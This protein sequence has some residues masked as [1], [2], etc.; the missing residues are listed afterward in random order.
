MYPSSTHHISIILSSIILITIIIFLLAN[1]GYIPIRYPDF[2]VAYHR[3][4]LLSSTTGPPDTGVQVMV[5]LLAAEGKKLKTD[6]FH[7]C[8]SKWVSDVY[9]TNINQH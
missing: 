1:V 6:G 3:S 8:V 7:W 4:H 2:S 9:I 5:K